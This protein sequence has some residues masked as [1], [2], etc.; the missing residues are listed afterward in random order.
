MHFYSY[1]GCD[2]YP[3][4]SDPFS[5]SDSEAS[6]PEPRLTLI[7]LLDEDDDEDEMEEQVHPLPSY[8]PKKPLPRNFGRRHPSAVEGETMKTPFPEVYH[9]INCVP[10]LRD[11]SLEVRLS[12]CIAI[13]HSKL[14]PRNSEWNVI[15]RAKSRGGNPLSQ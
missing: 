11:K 2:S 8:R 4:E 7:I 5:G 15:S 6:S 3:P 13:G 14:C 10:E 12:L 1:E 9:T